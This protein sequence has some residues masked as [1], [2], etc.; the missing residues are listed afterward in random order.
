MQ[1]DYDLFGVTE[2]TST[3]DV[4]RIYLILVKAHHPDRGG[5][6]ARF[7]EVKQAYDRLMSCTSDETR[8]TNDQLCLTW[9]SDRYGSSEEFTRMWRSTRWWGMAICIDF[10]C[11]RDRTPVRFGFRSHK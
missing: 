1:K 7:T 11:F 4:R 10:V 5:N 3:A 8:P 6:P 2:S 9:P